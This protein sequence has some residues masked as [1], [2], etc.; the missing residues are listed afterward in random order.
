MLCGNNIYCLRLPADSCRMRRW[1]AR[2]R[3]QRSVLRH[4]KHPSR[5]SR[6]PLQRLPQSGFPPQQQPLPCRIGCLPPPAQC[7]I[8]YRSAPRLVR[9]HW[10]SGCP[11]PPACRRCCFTPVVG[12]KLRR[13]LMVCVASVS[14]FSAAVICVPG[15]GRS[16]IV[17]VI[18]AACRQRNCHHRGKQKRSHFFPFLQPPIMDSGKHQPENVVF[19]RNRRA[20]FAQTG[21]RGMLLCS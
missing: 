18:A 4:W 1:Q 11:E 10:H 2:L 16:R 20:F 8:P 7:C 13:F 21:R 6:L 15:S 14:S 17:I 19:E 3:P 5:R 12:S 9:L